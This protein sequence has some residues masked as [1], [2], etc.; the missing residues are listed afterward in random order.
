MATPSLPVRVARFAACVAL[1]AAAVTPAPATAFHEGDFS[2]CTY[3][4][5]VV[6]VH[7]AAHHVV[8]LLVVDGH[9][10]FADLTDFAYRGRCGRAT[11]RNTDR[12]RVTETHAGESRLQ[13]DQ[14]IGR[15]APGRT[16]ESSG[17]SEIEVRL[18]TLKDIWVMGRDVPE[19]VTI[20][21]RGVNINGDGDADLI[22][23]HLREITLFLN[24]GADV[25]TASGGHG[26]GDAWL[27]TTLGLGA[28]GGDGQDRLEGTPRR[29]TLAGDAGADLLVGRGGGDFLDGGNQD[30]RIFGGYG[31]DYVYPGNG[32]DRVSAGVG[33]DFINA[34]DLTADT[35][36]G[37]PGHDGADADPVDTTRSIEYFR[38]GV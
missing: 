23:S 10:E 24:D 31:A 21:S 17:R 9:I 33:D 37:G 29:D 13:F 4:A 14:R 35:L 25:M 36:E 11:V 3:G 26:T 20:G 27:P 38:S 32:A 8:R 5:G 18:G 30:D 28:Y 7:L 15:F 6:H 2:S 34:D 12:I 16:R 19:L 1:L 22:G